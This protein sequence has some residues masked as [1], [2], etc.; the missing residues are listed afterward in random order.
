MPQEK[1]RG[2]QHRRIDFTPGNVPFN[3]GSRAFLPAGECNTHWGGGSQDYQ[4]LYQCWPEP[5]SA[6]ENSENE[7]APATSVQPTAAPA[8]E[9]AYEEVS[10]LHPLFQ[11]PLSAVPCENETEPSPIASQ[12]LTPAGAETPARLSEPEPHVQPTSVPAGESTF[13]ETLLTA[14]SENETEPSPIVLQTLTPA[15]A[16][17][18]EPTISLSAADTPRIPSENEPEHAA[19]VPPTLAPAGTSTSDPETSKT[20]APLLPVSTTVN[21]RPLT[22][23][24][25]R[26]ISECCKDLIHSKRKVT[27]QDVKT[28]IDST[29]ELQDLRKID[30]MPRRI[31]DRVRTSQIKENTF[32]RPSIS[33]ELTEEET[34]VNVDKTLVDRFP[35]DEVPSIA[36]CQET[37]KVRVEWQKEDATFLV[38]RFSRGPKYPGVCKLMSIFKETKDL[39][40]V[41]SENG[42]ARCI[43]KVKNLFKQ[44]YKASVS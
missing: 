7:Q 34:E 3:S 43:E 15:G 42:R 14:P 40:H 13:Q 22:G 23:K 30:G 8:G 10:S 37:G 41:W 11:E 21:Q 19:V 36:L 1:G 9:S 18:S 12:T 4:E 20:T 24:E 32:T 29:A 28:I 44:K 5:P 38:A 27:V 39:K 2:H 35:N 17:T 31:A 26:A 6:A 33:Q 16:A 25:K